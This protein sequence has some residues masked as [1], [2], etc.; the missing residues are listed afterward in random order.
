MK[1]QVQAFADHYLMTGKARESAIA[2][3]Y[4]PSGAH[5]QAN[6]LLKNVSVIAYIEAHKE[7]ASNDAGVTVGRIVQEL[8]W[9]AFGDFRELF[10]IDGD[11]KPIK[12]MTQAQVA[13]LS[14]LEI[15]G[16]LFNVAANKKR[17]DEEDDVIEFQP[18]KVGKLKRWD[19]VKALELLMKYKG[20]FEKDN[21]QRRTLPDI[22]NLSDKD[23]AA[24]AAM[25]KK[26]NK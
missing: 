9:I 2:A 13:L 24:L 12:D 17:V 20:M 21:E 1:A 14:S 22:S 15:E 23:K 16:D 26:T 5:T 6:R 7:K 3:G 10:T 11:L 8:A 4:A 18:V 19:K 25:Y